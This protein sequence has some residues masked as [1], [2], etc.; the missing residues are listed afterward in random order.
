M[1]RIA[2]YFIILLCLT[3]DCVTPDNFTCQ[4]ESPGGQWVNLT[5][6]VHYKSKSI[7]TTIEH[8]E[9][10]FKLYV[11]QKDNSINNM[12]NLKSRM[13]LEVCHHFLLD[14]C[15]QRY[16]WRWPPSKA[17]KL[18]S[19]QI[20]YIA[21]LIIPNGMPSDRHHLNKLVLFKNQ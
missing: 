9:H 20:F 5:I 14:G 1:S 17:N 10:I 3:P 8:C 19:R 16:G 15:K 18:D 11:C 13:I 21:S 7:H 6:C 12:K 4:R 2:P